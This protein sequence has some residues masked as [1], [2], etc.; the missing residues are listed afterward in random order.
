MNKLLGDFQVGSYH[1]K[2]AIIDGEIGFCGGM[3]MKENDW[4]T[5]LHQLFDPRRCRFSRPRDFREKVKEF[6]HPTDHLP[7]HDFIAE[8]RGRVQHLL[9][10]EVEADTPHLARAAAHGGADVVLLD[11]MPPAKLREAVALAKGRVFL[12]ASGGITLE[13]IRDAAA[14]GVDAI[15]VGALTHSVRSLD[16]SLELE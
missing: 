8:V 10:I 16:L 2:T 14:T 13:N 6:L 1:Q 3:N 7:R 9:R 12:E 5:R 4:D 11:N 15:S